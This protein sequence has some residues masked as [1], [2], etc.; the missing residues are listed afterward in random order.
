MTKAQGR[1]SNK[2]KG[3]YADRFFITKRN[4]ERKAAKYA[5]RMAKLAAKRKAKASQ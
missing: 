4:K 2:N 1:R 3:R 5:K